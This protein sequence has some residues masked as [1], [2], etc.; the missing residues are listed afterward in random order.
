MSEA[1]SNYFGVGGGGI[2]ER[3]NRGNHWRIWLL[4]IL[5]PFSLLLISTVVGVI[6]V[7]LAKGDRSAIGTY[8]GEW[9]SMILLVNHGL[10]FLLLL[11][12]MK[13]DGMAM[14]DIGWTIPSSNRSAL[15]IEVCVG[16][17]A[18]VVFYLLHQYVWGILASW[19]SQGVPSFRNASSSAPIGSNL[20]ISVAVG[21]VLGGVVEEQLYRGYVLT[22][23]TEKLAMP[24]AIT[25]MLFFF[26]L[27]HW[28]LGWTGMLVA[29]LTGLML[30]VLFVWRRSLYAVVVAHALIN[31]LVLLL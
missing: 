26:M 30:T 14:R 10:L 15:V 6:G 12:F 27:L 16:I 1:K 20:A 8:I 29:G 22:R 13:K 19:L 9:T 17:A 28:G 2:F 21:I 3:P 25:A 4:L 23:L 31:T 11:Y 24:V 5:P 18:G 7:V